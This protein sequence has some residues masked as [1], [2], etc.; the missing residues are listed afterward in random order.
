MVN[1]PVWADI[2]AASTSSTN[3]LVLLVLAAPIGEDTQT[4]YY[5]KNFADF[6]NVCSTN[7]LAQYKENPI[8]CSTTPIQSNDA[9]S[10]SW[11]KRKWK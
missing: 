3:I 10:F 2:G 11:S 1:K 9:Y 5:L 6:L 8:V 4:F 7:I